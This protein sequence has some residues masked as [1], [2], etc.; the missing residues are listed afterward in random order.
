MEFHRLATARWALVLL[1][2]S[3]A[4]AAQPEAPLV[5]L[6]TDWKVGET[7]R[8]EIVQERIDSADGKE[9]PGGTSRGILEA[10]VQ[11][12]NETGY[13]FVWTYSAGWFDE[14]AQGRLPVST[15]R[16]QEVAGDLSLVMQT[17]ESGVPQ[18]LLNRDEAVG[19][20]KRVLDELLKQ[21][22]GEP[23]PPPEVAEVVAMFTKPEVVESLLL[24]SAQV[25]YF[26]CG[27]ALAVGE[28]IEF[29]DALP[30]PFGGDPFPSKGSIAL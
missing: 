9:T 18:R 23:P 29:T 21:K 15:Q 16:L 20:F 26:A 1:L 30:N 28:A 3:A 10:R 5:E 11:A 8:L 27:A 12:R 22:P 24:R 14:I 17:D 7:L 6:P 4:A 19:V 13:V 25:F 2:S